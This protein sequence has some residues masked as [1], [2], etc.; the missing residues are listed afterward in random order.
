MVFFPLPFAHHQFSSCQITGASDKTLRQW[1]LNTGQ[2][3]LTMDI[4]WA[5][6]GAEAA[7]HSSPRRSRDSFSSA[8][9]GIGGLPGAAAAAGA[10]LLDLN[11]NFSAATPAYADGSWEMYTDF[12]GA[13][14]F[15][16]YALASAS[17]DGAVR[18]WD[19]E[20]SYMPPS[21]PPLPSL[22]LLSSL[23]SSRARAKLTVGHTRL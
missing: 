1:D 13:V 19:S 6:S 23:S 12:V 21:S 14:Q 16:G 2:C 8:G 7:L 3:V 15:W 22:S 20:F 18:M 5:A 4:L 9:L 11:G 17:G 10:P